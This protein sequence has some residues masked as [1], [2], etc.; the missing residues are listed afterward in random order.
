MAIEVVHAGGPCVAYEIGQRDT[1][2][3]KLNLLWRLRAK[4]VGRSHWPLAM[5]S[6]KS[7]M[8]KG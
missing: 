4:Q 1:P 6:A 5:K 8:S 2:H 7:G 3:I